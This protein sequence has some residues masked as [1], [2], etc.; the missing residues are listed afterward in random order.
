M[1]TKKQA[2][3]LATSGAWR[4]MSVRARAEFQLF[5]DRLCMPFDEFHKAIEETLG[6]PVFTH[7]FA[8]LN[9]LRKELRGEKAAP[10]FEEIM[11]LIPADKR[12]LVVLK[13]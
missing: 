1:L 7:E 9:H 10:T 11:S 4:E 8:E 13:E 12:L 6:R 2:I 5:E 3:K